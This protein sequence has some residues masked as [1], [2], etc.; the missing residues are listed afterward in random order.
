MKTKEPS[1]TKTSRGKPLPE[2]RYSNEDERTVPNEFPNEFMNSLT[3]KRA[4]EK[5]LPVNYYSNE[6]ERTVPY[7]LIKYFQ[8]EEGQ[9]WDF[10]K[11]VLG[12]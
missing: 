9:A 4:G 1:L 8:L 7:E 6:D 2:N 12:N 3:K 10:L 5:P 11:E